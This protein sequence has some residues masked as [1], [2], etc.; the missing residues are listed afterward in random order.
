MLK[1]LDE[2]DWFVRRVIQHDWQSVSCAKQAPFF[3]IR[4]A[5]AVDAERM[6]KF[7]RFFYLQDYIFKWAKYSPT[8]SKQTIR[9]LKYR[10][11]VRAALK[12]IK[13]LCHRITKVDISAPSGMTYTSPQTVPSTP[14]SV[15]VTTTWIPQQRQVGTHIVCALAENILRYRHQLFYG[16]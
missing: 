9:K 5:L 11:H 7:C 13:C 14:G 4:Y 1:L 16:F 3:K 6:L 2:F 10:Y 15:F 8:D 12:E